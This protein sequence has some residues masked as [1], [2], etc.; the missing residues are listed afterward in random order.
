MK[1]ILL[2]VI[3][4]AG[5]IIAAEA[6]VTIG[7]D[8]RSA[9]AA[10]LELR[11]QDA[12][13]P[14][15]AN[16]PANVTS[17]KGGLMLTRVMLKDTATLEPFIAITDPDWIDNSSSRIKETHAGLTVYNLTSNSIFSPGVYSWN[18]SRWENSWGFAYGAGNGLTIINDSL[19]IGGSLTKDMSFNTNG[20]AISFDGSG[21]LN[22]ATGVSL[23]NLLLYTHGQPGEGKIIIADDNGVGTWQN[24]HAL[25]TSPPTQMSDTGTMLKPSDWNSWHGAGTF[26]T[27]PPGKW[28][29]MV[30]MHVLID[31]GQISDRLWVKSTLIKV[32]ES[33]FN[34]NYYVGNNYLIS[35]RAYP[36]K[37]IISGYLVMKNTTPD[38]V[39]FEYSIGDVRG[40]SLA[41]NSI[42]IRQMGG[43]SF[44]ENAIVAFALD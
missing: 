33:N 30:T 38:P 12:A 1:H 24:N 39:R 3:A 16:D 36:G 5:S 2:A 20:H 14:A 27:L 43:K 10:I 9:R 40:L 41:G 42:R 23:T 11:T 19:H 4:T 15:S 44:A 28:F 13:N 6:Q 22:L 8:S 29:V 31:G 35:G 21:E 17:D 25:R 34:P 37:N 18:G 7:S 32:G 26:I